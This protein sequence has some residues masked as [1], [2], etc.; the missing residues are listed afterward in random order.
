MTLHKSLDPTLVRPLDIDSI[1]DRLLAAR[2][3]LVHLTNE[4]IRYLCSKAKDVLISQPALLELV[5]PLKICGDIQ[6]QYRDL[7]QVFE[8]CEFPP[9]ANYLFMGNYV[10]GQ[11]QSIETI[12]LLLAYKV[13]Y[14]ENFFLLRG[15]HEIQTVNRKLGF[16]AECRERYDVSLWRDINDV[17]NYLPFA[18]IVDDKILVV[19][20]GLS[21]DLNS[22]EDIRRI[23]RPNFVFD[24]G[25]PHD[26]LRTNPRNDITGWAKDDR[27]ARGSLVFGPDVV[28][29]FLQKHDLDLI[30]RAHEVVKDG[31]ELFAKKQL[32]T[33]FSAPNYRNQ[34][35]NSAAVFN[36]DESLKC[37]VQILK[38]A[39]D[40][41]QA[42]RRRSNA[43]SIEKGSS[44]W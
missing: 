14:P 27:D 12:C 31:F 25:L 23:T 18:A 36:V 19:H 30:C 26:L 15:S 20:G 44:F 24:S 11:G 10:D 16:Y 35:R 39:G 38:P 13:K 9:V 33:I 7:L 17:F 2:L 5:P 1:I 34:H 37:E 28:S 22:M 4:E 32:V 42:G 43:L 8:L 40:I 41:I 3:W 21:P 6:G 29:R